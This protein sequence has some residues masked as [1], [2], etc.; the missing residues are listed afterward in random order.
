MVKARI[1]KKGLPGSEYDKFHKKAWDKLN[2]AARNRARRRKKKAG[3]VSKGDNR[4][5]DHKVSLK[6]GGSRD[7]PSNQ[8][9]MNSNANKRKGPR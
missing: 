8:R 2:R 6:N 9:V 7:N 3:L 4:D 1:Y 5:V